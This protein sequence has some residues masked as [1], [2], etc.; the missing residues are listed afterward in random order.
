MLYLDIK[1]LHLISSTFP[2]FKR[3]RGNVWNCRCPYCGDSKKN[4]KAM[5]GYFYESKGDLKYKCHNCSIGKSF[6]YVLKDFNYDLYKEYNFELFRK[7]EPPIFKEEKKVQPVIK[8]DYETLLDKILDRL[9]KLSDDHEAV[10]YCLDRGIP[11]SVFKKIYYID[12]IRNISTLND[13]Y[14]EALNYNESR[15]F[16]PLYNAQGK[17]T[18]GCMRAI[19][20]SKKRYIVVKVREEDDYLFGINDIDPSKTVYVVEGPIDS[21][22]LE[23]AIAVSGISF[24]KIKNL[25]YNDI[26]YVIDNQPYNKEVCKVIKNLIEKEKKVVIWPTNDDTKVDIND[27]V[28]K[29]VDVMKMIKE[30]TFQGII[31]EMKFSQWKRC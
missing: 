4:Q 28:K 17:F 3:L 13:K 9:D 8:D 10:K 26:V 24:N 12:N 11:K 31:A 16:L 27:L 22:F 25:P 7:E 2:K 18:G 30:N 19:K 15:I 1:Y 6:K 5:R 23:N 29:G 14:K 20:E 21:L